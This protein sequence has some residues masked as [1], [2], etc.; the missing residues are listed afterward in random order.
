M[1]S[2]EGAGVVESPFV[3]IV[4]PGIVATGFGSTPVAAAVPTD[5]FFRLSE[6]GGVRPS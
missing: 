5:A 1:A 2:A 3:L 6:G 4:D